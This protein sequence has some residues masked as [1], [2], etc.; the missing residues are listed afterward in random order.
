MFKDSKYFISENRF[1][2]EV[3][4]LKC[5]PLPPIRDNTHQL[6]PRMSFNTSTAIAFWEYNFPN[7]FL[8][9]IPGHVIWKDAM[10]LISN[11]KKQG[12]ERLTGSIFIYAL[13]HRYREIELSS[14]DESF[15]EIHV[16]DPGTLFWSLTFF[17]AYISL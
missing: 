1:R 13:I 15:P 17:R 9:S 7:S 12:V 5:Y 14:A 8:G 11:S 4:E 6:F 16:L 2:F 10:Y 3:G